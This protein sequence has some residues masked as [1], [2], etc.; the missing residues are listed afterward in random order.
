VRYFATA[1]GPRV[2]DAMRA[3]LLGQIVTP[4]AGNRVMLGVDWCADNAVFANR[5]PGDD[6]YLAWLDARSWAAHRCAF[7]VAPDVV[8]DAAA[9]LR[10]S[11]PMLPRLRAAGY[12]AALAA[13]NGLEHLPVPWD[14]FDALFLGGDTA[15]KL[16]PHARR[17]TAE[18]KALG[19][20][21]HIGRVNSRRRLQIAAHMGCDS[22]DGTYL[23][24]AP[25]QNL[26]RLLDW[27][28]ELSDQLA[29]FD[30][31]DS[32]EPPP[33][34]TRVPGDFTTPGP[35]RAATSAPQAPR[36]SP[37]LA[38]PDPARPRHRR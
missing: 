30:L 8:A 25:D 14:E 18:A 27:L 2:R 23:A 22:A 7:A 17:L 6:T 31:S 37:T 5:Y 28:T 32:A 21:V 24:H 16:G 35:S 26:P 33:Q 20:W 15:W 4:A 1:S 10:R 11:A 38:L 12:R 34:T 29:L 3:G 19:K 13:Q 9:T 36:W